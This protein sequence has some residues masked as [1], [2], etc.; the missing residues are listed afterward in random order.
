[1]NTRN[2]KK[3]LLTL[4]LF[5]LL[6][7]VSVMAGKKEKCEVSEMHPTFWWAGMQ[8]PRLQVLIYGTGLDGMVPELKG[9]EGISIDE[10]VDVPNKHYIILYLNTK[11]ALPQQFSILLKD[12]NKVVKTLPYELRKSSV[13]RVE[14][15]DASDVVY[16]LMP[17]R[18]AT[19]TTD[20]EKKQMYAGMK[21]SSWGQEDMAR[22]GGDLKGLTAH[23]DYLQDLGITAIWPTPTLVNDMQKATYH[24]YAI[25]NYYETD[26]RFGTNEDYCRF[27]S[28]AHKR[29]I[30]V[31]KDI[32][33]NHCGSENFL[34]RDRPADDWFCYNSQYN[35]TTYKTGAVGDPHASGHDRKLAVDGWFTQFMPDF[36]GRNPLVA[37]YLIQASMFWI[38]YAGI[39]GIRQDTYPY[40]DFDFM[41]RWCLDIERQYPGFNIVGETWINN[42]VGVSYWQKGS[43]LAAPRNSELKTVMD[44]PLMYMLTSCVDEESDSWDNGFARLYELMSMDRVYADTGHLLTFLANHDTNRFQPTEEKAMNV[45]RY[46]QALTLLLTLRGIPQLYYGDEI[47]MYANK[48]VNDGALRQNFPGGW[49][50]DKNNAF[51]ADGRTKLQAEYHDFT[52][53]LLNWR[54]GNRAV[55]YGTLTHFPVREGIYVYARQWEGKTVTVVMNGTK[56]QQR[57]TTDYYREVMPASKA[58]EVLTGTDVEIADMLQLEPREIMILEF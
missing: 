14:S 16:L 4:G 11:N 23:L 7:W 43:P 47:G 34:F 57:I 22:H 33:F 45:T 5:N 30:K 58:H 2:L 35:Q 19:G 39:D 40:N 6:P 3:V 10:V 12:G 18:F 37:D 49:P 36:N 17:D 1:M 29:G 21:E 20:A 32:V 26:P 8:N 38:E 54:K 55:A 9:A 50:G 42:A 44:F 51:T 15:F 53:K 27:V 24:G 28:E 31:I 13:G 56:E 46:K 41:R 48:S 25:T 52:R